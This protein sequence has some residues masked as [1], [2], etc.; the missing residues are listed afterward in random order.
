MSNSKFLKVLVTPSARF[1][2]ANSDADALSLWLTANGVD[3]GWVR[4]DTIEVDAV[5]RQIRLDVF[6][7]EADGTIV[8]DE[9]NEPVIERLK[10][11]CDP[12]PLP[13]LQS[14]QVLEVD[15]DPS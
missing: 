3:P 12:T 6:A 13:A 15:D 1:G 14:T 4:L 10:W 7:H 8:K 5:R 11:E 9:N 2:T